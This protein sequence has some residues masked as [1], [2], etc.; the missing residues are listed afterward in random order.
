MSSLTRAQL[1]S[2]R[3]S[4]AE[5]GGG[6]AADDETG[7]PKVLIMTTN[8]YGKRSTVKDFTIRKRGG[9]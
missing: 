8:G 6:S 2:L 1:A 9:E 3:E 5:E 7:E 4:G